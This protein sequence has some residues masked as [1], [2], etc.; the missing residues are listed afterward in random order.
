ME[1]RRA[2]ADE[3]LYLPAPD[4]KKVADQLINTIYNDLRPA[5]ITCLFRTRPAKKN[6]KILPIEAKKASAL[7][8]FQNRND[9]LLIAYMDGWAEMTA[10]EREALIDFGLAHFNVT[11]LEKKDKITGNPY[12]EVK[13]SIN[14]YDVMDFTEVAIRRG[15]WTEDR[16]YYMESTTDPL[17]NILESRHDMDPEDFVESL[18]QAAE[19]VCGIIREEEEDADQAQTA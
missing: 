4:V 18:I 8:Q 7:Q 12:E 2:M 19:A 10:V 17:R 1:R 16:R 13:F 14:G 9:F 11:I 6:G 15:P 3:D 5:R